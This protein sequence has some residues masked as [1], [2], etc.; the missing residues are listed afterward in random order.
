MRPLTAAELLQIWDE[1]TGMSLL[2][3]TLLLL[4]K[5]Y[6]IEDWKQLGKSSIGNRDAMLLQLREWM[7]GNKLK[8]MAKCP[9]CN[10]I[11]EWET[12]TD[13]LH[14]Q[15]IQ[16]RITIGIFSLAHGQLWP[17]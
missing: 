3:K 4:G 2:E 14:L 9:A 17:G 11:V 13:D 12:S 8:N 5:A 15:S 16:Q 6:A 7:F 10:E 1:G